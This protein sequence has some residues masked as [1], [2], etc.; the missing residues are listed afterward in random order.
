M[1]LTTYP[2]KSF[3]L[4]CV[5]KKLAVKD[6]RSVSWPQKSTFISVITGGHCQI[7]MSAPVLWPGWLGLIMKMVRLSF[8]QK[9][10]IATSFDEHCSWFWHS[11]LYFSFPNFSA[12]HQT[13]QASA[14]WATGG[15]R[16]SV[17]AYPMGYQSLFGF[18]RI[19]LSSFLNYSVALAFSE[20]QNSH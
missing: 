15:Q 5:T 17:A 16:I 9:I 13:W 3:A 19:L 20:R 7:A 12:L 6:Q 11:D 8:S 2:Q 18:C 1:T 14:I 4:T 10:M